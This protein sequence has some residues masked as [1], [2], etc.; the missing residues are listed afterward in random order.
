M[1]ARLALLNEEELYMVHL[2]IIEILERTGVIVES[3]K[4]KK[5]PRGYSC[6]EIGGAL[7]GWD[8]DFPEMERLSCLEPLFLSPHGT[9]S[10]RYVD[11]IQTAD[12]LLATWQQSQPDTSQP[13]VGHAV[14]LDEVQKLLS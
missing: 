1:K 2:A 13:L 6:E 5:R 3:E 4:A 8:E 11:V 12:G 10:S 9:G 7:F 14:P